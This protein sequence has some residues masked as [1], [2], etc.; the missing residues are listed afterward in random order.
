MWMM[1]PSLLD[2]LQSIA[3]AFTCESFRT[4]CQ[5]LLGW[6]LCPGSHSL[7]R[8]CQT[9]HAD[10][11]PSTA[12]PHRFHRFYNF[13]NRSAWR[14][15]SLGCRL[16][17]LVLKRLRLVGE[18]TLVVDDT[19]LHKRGTT[20]WGFGWFR[21]AVASTKKR[22]ATA[23][24]N[25]WVVI[26]LVISIP[27]C[28]S[29][30]LCLSLLARL[31]RGG[32]DQPTCVQLAKAMLQEVATWF[33]GLAIILTADGAYSA[34]ELLGDLDPRV[35]YVGR[36]RADAAVYDPTVPPQPSSKRGVKPKKGPRLPC[37]RDAAKMADDNKTKQGPYSWQEVTVQAYAKVRTLLAFS[38]VVVWPHVLDLRPVKVVVVRDPEGKMDDVYL[39]T[40]RLDATIEWVI[41]TYAKRWSIEVLFRASKQVM[42]IEGPQQWAAESIEKTAAWVWQMMSVIVVW[43]LTAGHDLPEA[44]EAREQM[45]EWESEWSF[46]HM[47][48]V[49]RRAI[50]NQTIRDNSS[51]SG[52][53]GLILEAFRNFVLLLD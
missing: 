44:Q 20:V 25:N 21:D 50:V 43:Y 47:V 39:F 33:P 35:D 38:Y 9:V 49:L 31:H 12:Q 5:L 37:P 18:I 8:V 4:H 7:F 32:E 11:Y 41:E 30:E 27:F 29:K 19:L 17:L 24:G 45:G 2:V 52:E 23:S 10:A 51:S 6:L 3:P 40:T 15:T 22:V 42:K 46:R 48:N 1:I 13:F 26:G 14:V 36:M 16:A 34:E 53:S 28:P